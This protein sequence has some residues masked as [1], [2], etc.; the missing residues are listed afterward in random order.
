MKGERK[1][2]VLL[3]CINPTDMKNIEVLRGQTNHN[4]IPQ[5]E[6]RVT[7]NKKMATYL[8]RLWFFLSHENSNLLNKTF[9]E[10]VHRVVIKPMKF[11]QSWMY[12][13]FKTKW[14]VGTGMNRIKLYFTGQFFLFFINIS[15]VFVDLKKVTVLR[16]SD[17]KSPMIS[18]P[19]ISTNFFHEIE[20]CY[21]HWQ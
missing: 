19:H 2:Q 5:S 21:L 13:K 17:I 14:W 11:Q 4:K 7:W 9:L 6:Q 16:W 18:S 12:S 3:K 20:C 15:D 8:S 10:K 1:S